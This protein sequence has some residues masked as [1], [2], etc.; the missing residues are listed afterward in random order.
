MSNNISSWLN[1]VSFAEERTHNN[2]TFVPLISN[3]N[4]GLQF[5]TLG[6]VLKK[7]LVEINVRPL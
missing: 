5:L 3:D 1:K 2:L 6:K 7:K 4:G